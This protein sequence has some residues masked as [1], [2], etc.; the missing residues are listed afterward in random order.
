MFPDRIFIFTVGTGNIYPENAS[1]QMRFVGL[2]SQCQTS[3]PN[4]NF[5]LRNDSHLLL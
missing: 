5:Y 4:P 1:L 2:R 3:S